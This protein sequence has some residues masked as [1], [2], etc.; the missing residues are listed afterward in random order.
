[1]DKAIAALES[2]A[3]QDPTYKDSLTLLG[4]AYYQKGRLQDAYAIL[5]RAL[6]VNKN[7]EIAWIVLGMVQLKLGQDAKGL[8]SLQGGITLLSKLSVDGYRDFAYWDTRGLVRS[9]IRRTAFLSTKGLEEKAQ[10]VGSAELLLARI[11]EEENLR[12]VEEPRERQRG[13]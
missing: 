9:S 3:Q 2:V 10:L 7:D 5:Q 4:R 13:G 12:R 8:E 1:M 11:D 6:A